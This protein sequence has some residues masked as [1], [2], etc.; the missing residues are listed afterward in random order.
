MRE[1]EI[2]EKIEQFKRRVNSRKKVGVC[3]MQEEAE[4]EK[5]K[6]SEAVGGREGGQAE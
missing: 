1:E 4:G 6:R 2:E 5:R 3:C